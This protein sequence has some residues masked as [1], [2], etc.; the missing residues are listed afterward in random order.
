MSLDVNSSLGENSPLFGSE[1]SFQGL[2]GW[3]VVCSEPMRLSLNIVSVLPFSSPSFHPA[4]SLFTAHLF[5]VL[6]FQASGR[7]YLSEEHCA[8]CFPITIASLQKE[9]AL[10]GVSYT[11]TAKGIALKL[12]KKSREMSQ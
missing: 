10:M 5:E 12:Y 1:H 6:L 4:T 2:A 8:S 7:L 3:Q 11:V 9:M